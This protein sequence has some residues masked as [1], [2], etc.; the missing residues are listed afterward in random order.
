[1]FMVVAVVVTC[2]NNFCARSEFPGVIGT[3][4][5]PLRLFY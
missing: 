5:N 4:M 2:K 1:M 3:A